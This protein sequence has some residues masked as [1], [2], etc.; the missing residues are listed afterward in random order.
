MYFRKLIFVLAIVLIATACTKQAQNDVPEKVDSEAQWVRE[1]AKKNPLKDS[2]NITSVYFRFDTILND[3]EV[4]GI[5]YPRSAENYGWE[6]HESGVRLFFHNLK[7][8]KEY[9]WTNM[10]KVEDEFKP[11]F[12]SI[13]VTNIICDKRS[14]AFKDG[15]A[16]IFRYDTRTYEYSDNAL[17]PYAE[18]QFYD[19]DFDG[20]D[21]LILGYYI[22]G[23]HSSPSYDI[24]ELTDSGLVRKEVEGESYFWLDADTKFDQ[25]NRIITNRLHEGAYAWG[26][27]VYKVDDNGNIHPWYHVYF[28]SDSDH[29]ILS[30]DTTFYQ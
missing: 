25:E 12:M 7:T 19:A 27:Y 1:L 22:G 13:N 10:D 18:Y 2:S 5:L 15:D 16:Y 9:I 23:P 3:F 6:A 17:L 4:S 29:N 11:Y 14:K 24:Y 26:D 30:A 8:D 21:E 28:V 20:E